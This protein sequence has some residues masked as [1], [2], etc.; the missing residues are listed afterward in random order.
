MQAW[1]GVAARGWMAAGTLLS[2]LASLPVAAQGIY[3]CV[4]ATGKRLTS[5]RPI[6]NCND[7][8]QRLLNKDGSTRQV[9]PPTPTA[10]ERA[11][12][13][14]R[15]AQEQLA[16]ANQREAVRRDRNLLARFPNEAAHHK[17]REAA[18][19]DIRA[20]LKRSEVRLDVLA[21]ERKPLVE[22][23]E[24]YVGRPLPPKLK[25]Q[26][27]ANDASVEA[28]KSLIA[29]QKA[30]IVRISTLYDAELDRL[31]KLWGGATPGSMG[32]IAEAPA[33][34]APAGKAPARKNGG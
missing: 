4:D 3:T 28:Q 5:D 27:E 7:R 33:T 22:E 16:R 26:I 18:L 12:Q 8:E 14:A 9:V 24:F 25:Q 11:A 23:T 34:S 6:P 20:A 19:D 30:E 21:K 15:E 32:T 2:A 10:D 13:E 1:G 31:K 29:T 17:A